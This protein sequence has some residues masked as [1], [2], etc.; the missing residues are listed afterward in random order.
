MSESLFRFF[1][2]DSYKWMYVRV[3]GTLLLM[4]L[5]FLGTID[6]I[7]QSLAP[8]T[9]SGR[10][11]DVKI[12]I[13]GG[14]GSRFAG[15][16]TYYHLQ[17]QGYKRNFWLAEGNDLESWFSAPHA[18]KKGD[19]ASFKI[20]SEDLDKL[21]MPTVHE[22][23]GPQQI[24]WPLTE[25]SIRMYG[26]DINGKTVL[27]AGNTIRGEAYQQWFW[28]MVPLFIY[29]LACLFIKTQFRYW[30][31]A[32]EERMFREFKKQA[33]ANYKAPNQP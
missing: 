32:A 27:S 9:I 14:T 4:L 18:I 2:P 26:L 11:L 7:D 10:V 29:A 17:I 15:R 25:S 5:I 22:K 28:V 6:R 20:K 16:S 13:V 3:A 21:Q 30:T 33:N 1:F 24:D 8:N 31:P 19:I 23:R 12:G